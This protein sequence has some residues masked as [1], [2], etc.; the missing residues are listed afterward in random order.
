MLIKNGTIYDAVNEKPY[1]ADILI[2]DGKI[3]SIGEEVRFADEIIDVKGNYILPGFI[4]IHVH[5]G[6]GADFMD[7][8]PEAFETVVKAHLKCGTTT[9][10]PTAM[11]AAWTM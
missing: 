4:D 5:G 10:L 1:V 9:L 8:T 6:G 7:A 3:E 2:K 11:T